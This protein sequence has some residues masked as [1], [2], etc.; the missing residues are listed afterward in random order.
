MFDVAA[1]SLEPQLSKRDV[2]D[3]AHHVTTRKRYCS[4]ES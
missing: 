1:D 4:W 2:G 3:S